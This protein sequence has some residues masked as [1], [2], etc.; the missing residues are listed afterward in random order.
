MQLHYHK[1]LS[2]DHNNLIFDP[3]ESRHIVKVLR[4]SVGDSM[5]VTNGNGLLI[6]GKIINANP[7]HCE[8]EIITSKQFSKTHDYYLHIGIAPTKNIDRFE[9]FLEKATEIG[10][11]HITPLLCERSERKVVKNDRLEKILIA[12]MK[13]SVQYHLP[14]LDELQK[15][16]DF[17]KKPF[18][19]QRFIA[20]CLPDEKLSFKASLSQ[21]KTIQIL[22]GPE[23]DFSEHEI[24]LALKQNFRPIT[25]GNTRLRTET[26]GIVATHTVNLKYSV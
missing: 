2:K 8:L 5:Y 22:I 7:K 25:L 6:N 11:D 14:V 12:A 10:V 26:A 9:W 19:G 1:E 17:I 20:H 3:V 13:Q 16:A 24:E 15:Y 18:E 4:H 21:V 23:G